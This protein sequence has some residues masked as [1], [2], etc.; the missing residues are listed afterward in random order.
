M[1]I[2]YFVF[3][4]PCLKFVLMIIQAAAFEFTWATFELHAAIC[5]VQLFHISASSHQRHQKMSQVYEDSLFSWGPFA[6]RLQLLW[7]SSP[8]GAALSSLTLTLTALETRGNNNEEGNCQQLPIR[9]F[10]LIYL[11]ILILFHYCHFNFV[12]QSRKKADQ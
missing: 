4:L 11:F 3:R 7:G 2:K 10:L 9:F 8:E 12:F 1:L 5:E 6:F